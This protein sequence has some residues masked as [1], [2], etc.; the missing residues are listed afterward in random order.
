MCIF[1]LL[2]HYHIIYL[3]EKY[4]L[5]ADQKKWQRAVLSLL[6]WHC[7]RPAPA[8]CLS[9]VE[10]KQGRAGVWLISRAYFLG[11]FITV[12]VFAQIKPTRAA[13]FLK[14]EQ[15]LLDFKMHWDIAAYVKHPTAQSS[16]ALRLSLGLICA[17]HHLC[18]FS[19]AS[20]CSQFSHWSCPRPSVQINRPD[21]SPLPPLHDTFAINLF[22]LA[23]L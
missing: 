2:S 4:F 7:E 13:G 18:C 16:L 11:P 6:G 17:P 12:T 15:I 5:N 1:L 20:C 23:F 14:D 9:W 3:K 8:S 21:R 10:L 19:V 22:C